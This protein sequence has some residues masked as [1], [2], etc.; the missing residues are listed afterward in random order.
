[1]T[2]VCVLE[3][4]MRGFGQI[5]DLCRIAEPTLG[6]ITNGARTTSS[7]SARWRAWRARRQS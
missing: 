1:M 4:A 6:V 5:A 2:A 3:L 7:S